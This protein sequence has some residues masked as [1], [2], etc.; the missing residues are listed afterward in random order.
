MERLMV[1]W[2][3]P[4]EG[5]KHDRRPPQAPHWEDN[6]GR[7]NLVIEDEPVMDWRGEPLEP[8][9]DLVDVLEVGYEPEDEDTEN[10]ED[11]EDLDE[12]LEREYA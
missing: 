12:W 10:H 7:G 1:V 6:K 2:V 8:S 3:K 11:T 5:F 9:Y 4:P